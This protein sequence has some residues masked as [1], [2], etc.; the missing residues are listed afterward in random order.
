MALSFEYVNLF[1]CGLIRA[2]TKERGF[3]EVSF[4]LGIHSMQRGTASP[5]HG[6]TRKRSTNRLKRTGK[7]C[8]GLPLYP[9]KRETIEIKI[10]KHRK[11]QQNHVICSK[12]KTNDT[13]LILL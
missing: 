3:D 9:R 11:I 8:R 12:R 10:K 4:L 2:S 5:R 1:D 7:L 6:V 13:F